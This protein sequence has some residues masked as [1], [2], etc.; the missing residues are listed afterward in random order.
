MPRPHV[1]GYLQLFFPDS[2]ISTSTVICIQIEFA[3][4]TTQDSSRIL[5][6]IA[7]IMSESPQKSK[8]NAKSKVD[9]WVLSYLS[10]DE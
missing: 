10:L 2:N 6:F 7:R 3:H 8:K 9:P 1:S 5:D 4:S